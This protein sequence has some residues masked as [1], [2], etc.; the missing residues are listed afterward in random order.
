VPG[1]HSTSLRPQSLHRYEATAK[2]L[3]KAGI[4]YEFADARGKS[5]LAQM[6]SLVLLGD[7]CSF[8][9]AMLNRVDPTAIDAINFVKQYLTQSAGSRD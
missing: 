6:M 3:V 5:A 9:L 8:Y 1:Y 2:L 4:T 7:Y